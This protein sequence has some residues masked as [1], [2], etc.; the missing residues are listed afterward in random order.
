M[1]AMNVI[2]VCLDTFRADAL[3]PE[4][5][6]A[7]E[8]ETPNLDRFLQDAVWFRQAFGEGLP[9]LQMRRGCFTGRRSFPWRFNFD[10]RGHWH[11]AYGWHKIPPEHDTLAEI[12][13]RRGYATGLVAD[14]YHMFKPTMNYTR[15]FLSYEFIRGQE[16][17]NWKSGP[18]GL[19]RE[20]AAKHTPDLGNLAR[21]V[22]LV[23]YLHNQRG[24]KSEKDYQ[25]ARVFRS[26]MNWIDDNADN[27]PFFLW[28]DSFD[29]HEPWDPPAPYADR[30]CPNYRR[31]DYILPP[32]G[33]VFAK[34]PEKEKKR[35]RALYLGEV[36]FV[37]SWVGA[38]LKH[39][40]KKRLYDS[41][42]IFII[43]DHGTQLLDRGGF[44]K[45]PLDLHPFNTR[46]TW[47]MR[48]PDAPEGKP[49]D[50][51][52]QNHDL[53][54]TILGLLG[55]EA[56][57]D[58]RSFWP[59]VEGDRSAARDHVVTGWAG[60]GGDDVG[61]ASV[62]DNEWNAIF[63]LGRPETAPRLFDLKAD[64]EERADVAAKHPDALKKQQQRLETVLGAPLPFLF[65][66]KAGGGGPAPSNVF[67][68]TRTKL[69]M[70]L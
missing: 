30:Y 41:S 13:L 9:T 66:E 37:D 29:P 25:C 17:D 54:P 49:I 45:T 18:L 28:V 63:N 15:G 14:S 20:Q 58:G 65:N 5:A 61:G 53:A 11:H 52:I 35:I 55:Y 21:Q 6:L 38:F 33:P 48:H 4:D 3:Y 56:P 68:H 22:T 16:N 59:L 7:G 70:P 60:F 57:M 46:Q 24:R 26:A 42:L 47:T 27:G 50:G 51:F 12:L 1:P 10:R 43:S 2:C 62:R 36:T 64:P 8:V 67:Y 44:G 31:I 32:G 23:Q 69:R 40:K 34:L 39:L 19:I